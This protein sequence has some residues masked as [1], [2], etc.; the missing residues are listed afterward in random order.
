[1]MQHSFNRFLPNDMSW[2]DL[3]DMVSN[4]LLIKLTAFGTCFYLC[5]RETFDDSLQ[6]LEVA[7]DSVTSFSIG[8]SLCQKARIFSNVTANV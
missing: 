4:R 8:D 2:R 3:F 5:N 7:N 1:M 6:K